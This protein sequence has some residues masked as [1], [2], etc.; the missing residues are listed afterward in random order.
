MQLPPLSLIGGKV[1]IARVT[2]ISL[3]IV[4]YE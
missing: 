1:S 2:R 3:F 4:Y